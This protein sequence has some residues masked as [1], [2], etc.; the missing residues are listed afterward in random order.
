MRHFEQQKLYVSPLP[1][2]C[3][4]PGDGEGWGAGWA[5]APESGGRG[6]VD[7]EPERGKVKDPPLP[8][9]THT[10]IHTLAPLEDQRSE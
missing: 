3:L 9:H 8:L 7:G 10:H 5:G 6:G 4:P 1:P 2:L